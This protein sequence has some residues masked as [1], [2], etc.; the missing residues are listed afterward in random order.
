MAPLKALSFDVDVV[1]RPSRPVASLPCD[2]AWRSLP[3]LRRVPIPPCGLPR[4][5]VLLRDVP[6]LLVALLDLLLTID[7]STLVLV[8]GCMI[9]LREVASPRL[10]NNGFNQAALNHAACAT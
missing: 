6:C 10:L 1:A 9:L 4:P 5:D 8:L 3:V 2:C 7:P